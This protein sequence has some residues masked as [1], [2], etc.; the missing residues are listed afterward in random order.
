MYT[1]SRTRHVCYLHVV[2]FQHFDFQYAVLDVIILSY[3]MFLEQL[4]HAKTPL[5]AF[6]ETKIK[7]K[8]LN[9]NPQIIIH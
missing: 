6:K 7:H 4:V 5:Q 3:E 2:L 8:Y 9:G 1:Y